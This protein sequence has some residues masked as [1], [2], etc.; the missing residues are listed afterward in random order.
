MR[1]SGLHGAA[2]RRAAHHLARRP[3]PR[4]PAPRDPRPASKRSSRAS[5]TVFAKEITPA[6]EDAGIRFVDWDDLVGRRP[7]LRSR[8]CSRSRIF[9][10]LTPLAVDPAHPFPYISNLS[11]NLAV[12]VRDPSTRR[13]ALRAGEGAAAAA[14]LR[15]PPRRRALRAARAGDRGEARLA[16]PRAWRC[17][18]TTRSGSPATPTSSSRTKPRTSS[19]RSSRCCAAAASSAGSCASRSTPP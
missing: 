18:R 4:R 8:R 10:V 9:P 12:T 17:S 5:A 3:R 11:L 1:V 2:R 15:R 13:G 6:L 7:R 14:P 19:R 16:V